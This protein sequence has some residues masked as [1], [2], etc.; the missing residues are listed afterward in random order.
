[1]KCCLISTFYPNF[2]KKI[3]RGKC[4]YSW[5][6]WQWV[7]YEPHLRLYTNHTYG[8]I[9]TT[10]TV[11]NGTF[12]FLHFMSYWEKILYRSFITYFIQSQYIVNNTQFWLHVSANQTILRPVFI[13]WKYIQC[14]RA[15]CDPILFTLIKAKII[16][17]FNNFNFKL[18]YF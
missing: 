10:L 6:E 3:M 1:M 16:P 14:V 8:C 4:T 13:I 17:V 9:R 12:R 5:I 7:E 11:V 15:L 18:I 2:I